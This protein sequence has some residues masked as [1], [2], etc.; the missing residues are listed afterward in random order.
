M[1]HFTLLSQ[2]ED[3]HQGEKLRQ[4]AVLLWHKLNKV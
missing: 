1:G 4:K 3:L 2:R